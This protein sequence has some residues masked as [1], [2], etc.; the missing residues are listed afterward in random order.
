MQAT[1]KWLRAE[2]SPSPNLLYSPINKE[3][4]S[5]RFLWR[6]PKVLPHYLNEERN[7]EFN[8]LSRARSH[9]SCPEIRRSL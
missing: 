2:L 3:R 6:F 1:F 8:F 7:N 4:Y 5:Q 9:V